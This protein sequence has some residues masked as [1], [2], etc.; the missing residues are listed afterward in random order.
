MFSWEKVFSSSD[1]NN[2]SYATIGM[3]AK[4]FESRVFELEYSSPMKSSKSNTKIPVAAN[5]LKTSIVRLGQRALN[6][7][8]QNRRFSS[9]E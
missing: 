5:F 3:K 2:L 6:P 1:D 8:A 9:Q 7:F 4:T